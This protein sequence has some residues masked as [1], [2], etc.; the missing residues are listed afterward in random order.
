MWPG[1][2]PL[3]LPPPPSPVVMTDSLPVPDGLLDPRL[4]SLAS[5]AD[6]EDYSRPIGG[7]VNNKM[8]ST[9]TFDTQD[10]VMTRL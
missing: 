5:L 10:S 4:E 9:T 8:H 1:S 6:H 2:G 3:T 7:V